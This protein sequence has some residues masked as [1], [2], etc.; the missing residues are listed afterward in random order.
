M[1]IFFAFLF[2]LLSLTVMSVLFPKKQI[3]FL[4]A[5]CVVCWLMCGLKSVNVGTD[6]IRY[7]ANY[8]KASSMTL[9]AAMK[10]GDKEYGFY[11]INWLFASSK[12][13][14]LV[15]QLFAYL[16]IWA[17]VFFCVLLLSNNKGT[18]FF[19][20]V[21]LLI[22]FFM[23]GLRQSIAIS[24]IAVSFALLQLASKKKIYVY[25]ISIPLMIISF[26]FHMTA[27]YVSI[28]IIACHFL[29][30][31]TKLELL[32]YIP[33][34]LVFIATADSMYALVVDVI[35]TEY[36]PSDFKGFPSTSIMFFI[37]TIICYLILYKRDK[38]RYI[39]NKYF[40]KIINKILKENET[41]DDVE[42]NYSIS[43]KNK[44]QCDYQRVN[45]L[46]LL[47]CGVASVAM[48]FSSVNSNFMRFG[49]YFEI[50][51]ALALSNA[52]GTIKTRKVRV[53]GSI[54]FSM[55]LLAYFVIMTLKSPFANDT[56]MY[57]F[58]SN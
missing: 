10:I 53:V 18:S 48:I 37:F 23:T 36:N 26:L 49:Y 29:F 3:I 20:I 43:S 14:Y 51:V 35:K 30:L 12:V 54:S 34:Y 40:G 6:S 16:I 47:L 39:A 4:I 9:S 32:I 8:Q 58:W 25:F 7:F 17:N 24:I 33:I 31:D 45:N 21:C 55:I 46:L 57:S 38:A 52:I 15:F 42:L 5:A 41:I 27:L 22:S 56:L 11:F 19:I 50:F 28:L 2:V 44:M 13:P 1:I